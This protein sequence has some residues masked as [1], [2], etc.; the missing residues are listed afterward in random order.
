MRELFKGMNAKADLADGRG[1]SIRGLL[2]VAEPRLMALPDADVLTLF[3]AG[4]MHMVSLHLASL[5]NMQKLVDR[6][7]QRPVPLQVPPL[8]KG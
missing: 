2:V 4:E 8:P 6:L 7:A 1:F 3:R 5:A